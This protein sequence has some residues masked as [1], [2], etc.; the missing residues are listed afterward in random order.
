MPPSSAIAGGGWPIN[1]VSGPS[2]LEAGEPMVASAMWS[3]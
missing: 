2:P 3:P 1:R